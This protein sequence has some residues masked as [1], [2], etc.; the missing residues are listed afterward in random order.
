MRNFLIYLVLIIFNISFVHAQDAARVYENELAPF[1]GWCL[2]DHAMAKI[3]ADKESEGQRCQ[4]KIDQEIETMQ[5]LYTFEVDK[6]KIRLNTLQAEH[7]EIILIK[8]TEI[9]KL[10]QVAL[11]Q[12]ND[13]WYLFFSGGVVLGVLSTVGIIYAVK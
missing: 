7:D 3:I 2:T 13:Y 12:P 5:A 6:L 10:E 11:E 4:L 1:T 9:Q 8:N